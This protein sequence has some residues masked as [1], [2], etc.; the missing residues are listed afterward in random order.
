MERVCQKYFMDEEVIGFDLEWVAESMRWQG[1]RR[2]ASLIQLAS[3]SRIALFHVAVFADD[4]D[5]VGPSF[6]A[7]MENEGITKVGV[8]IRG[9]ATRLRNQLDIHSRGLMELSHM[10]KLIKYSL[11]GEH[12]LINKRLVP[13]AVQ[14][15]EYLHL[16]LFKG[17]DVRTSNWTKPLNAQQVVYSASDAYAG[18][19]LYATYEHHRKQLNPCPPIPHHVERDLPIRVA[20]C[21]EPEASE[22][23]EAAIEDAVGTSTSVPYVASALDSIQIED[24]P[25]PP[26]QDTV[27]APTTKPKRSGRTATPKTPAPEVASPAA[28]HPP[29]PPADTHIEED[30]DLPPPPPELDA[31]AVSTSEPEPTTSTATPETPAEEVASPVAKRPPE[32][33]V[34]ARVEAAEDRAK[35]FRIAN[36]VAAG[37]PAALFASFVELRAFYLWHFYDLPP[38]AVAQLLPGRMSTHLQPSTVISYI[39]HAIHAEGVR[40]PPVD[41]HRVRAELFAGFSKE[42]VVQKRYPRVW[43]LVKMAEAEEEEGGGRE[44]R[45]WGW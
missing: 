1:P 6:R 10:H 9:D 25:P 40:L 19:H 41:A 33:P 42:S 7:I 21:V 4:D 11:T 15:E 43:R 23:D 37:V 20:Q 26:S 36:P 14:V 27:A 16:P 3:P 28:K 13:L 32:P 29:E 31:A 5:M 12:K 18:V 30:E 17:L 8:N 24:P 35:V 39:L 22:D 38:A 45:G 2:N 44:R 34:D